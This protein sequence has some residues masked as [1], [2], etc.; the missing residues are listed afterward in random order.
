VD[1]SAVRVGGAL[2]QNDQP[3]AFYSNT[4][5][6]AEQRYTVIEK[7]C[8]SIYLAFDKWQ[9]LLY[10]KSDITVQTDHQPLESISKKPLNKA[11]RRLQA[12]RMRL[13]RWSFV[14][15]YKKGTQQ[16]IADTLSRTSLP[17]L[18][19]ANLSGGLI[20]RVEL[21]TMGLDNSGISSVTLENLREQT[22]LDPALQ[23]LSLLIVTW[24]AN[25]KT[26]CG[27]LGTTLLHFQR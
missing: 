6:A 20:L 13:Q 11:P 12:M 25:C 24:L 19:T 21:E 15:S 7:E 5:T 10:R 23:K 14:V 17:L 4:L 18:S 3:V 26:R 2:L 9:S 1:S 27:S 8:L 16:I 22:A